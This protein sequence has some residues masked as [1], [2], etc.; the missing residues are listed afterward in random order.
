MGLLLHGMWEPP[1]PW[2]KP[3]SLALQGGLLTT[4]PPEKP[5]II[6]DRVPPNIKQDPINKQ[7]IK[8]LGKEFEVPNIFAE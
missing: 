6:L 5:S 2:I 3:V 8:L 7:S 1:G 4:G